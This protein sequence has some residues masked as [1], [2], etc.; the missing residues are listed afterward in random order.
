MESLKFVKKPGPGCYATGGVFEMP[1]PIISLTHN[2]PN[3]NLKLPVGAYE[4]KT[5]KESATQAQKEATTVDTSV[6]NTWQLNPTQFT[7]H[8]R[9]WSLQ[10]Q[11]LLVKVTGELGCDAGKKVT[12]ELYKLLLHEPGGYFKVS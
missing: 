1:L 8:N 9:Y 3:A 6:H 5:I 7:I 4:V 10:L 12:C 2:A 11:A